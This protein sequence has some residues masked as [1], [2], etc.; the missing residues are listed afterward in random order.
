MSTP[1]GHVNITIINDIRLRNGASTLA[2][3]AELLVHPMTAA[4]LVLSGVAV[5]RES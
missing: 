1:S 2:R 5:R 3:G 4:A